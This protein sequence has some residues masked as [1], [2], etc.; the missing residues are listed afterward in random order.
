MVLKWRIV[1][2]RA[3]LCSKRGTAIFAFLEELRSWLIWAYI[4]QC[5]MSCNDGAHPNSTFLHEQVFSRIKPLIIKRC[6]LSWFMFL[7]WW[8]ALPG[9]VSYTDTTGFSTLWN[10]RFTLT[11]SISTRWIAYLWPMVPMTPITIDRLW[12]PT[13]RYTFTLD[14]YIRH[15][16]CHRLDIRS[17]H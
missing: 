8:V 17:S 12:S 3:L 1:K 2:L 6:K 10:T 5:C 14:N 7:P 16:M 13:S 15:T 9:L 4:L 11:S